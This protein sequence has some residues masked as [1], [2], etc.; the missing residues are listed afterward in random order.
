MDTQKI[1]IIGRN[2]LVNE[3]LEAGLEVA[4]PLRDRGVDLIAYLDVDDEIDRFVAFPIQLKVSSERRFGVMRKYDR[5]PN[6]ILAYVWGIGVGKIAVTYALTQ[7][8]ATGIAE[9]MGW[10]AT[11]SWE[12][13]GYS[14]AVSSRLGELL[15]PFKM[16]SSS[17]RAKLMALI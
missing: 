11:A 8:E 1:E 9:N 3:L 13:G 15:E 5:F 10:T 14:S 17:W 12:R 4:E 7:R 6:L 2:R 16:T